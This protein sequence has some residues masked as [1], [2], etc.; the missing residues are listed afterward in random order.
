[1][2]IREGYMSVE[3]RGHTRPDVCAG[4]SAMLHAAALGLR[5]LSKKYPRLIRYVADVETKE[6]TPL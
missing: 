4:A 1:M 5:E 6:W 2:I 3:I